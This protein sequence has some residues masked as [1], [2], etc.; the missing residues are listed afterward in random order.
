M[1]TF[2]GVRPSDRV[3]AV[4]MNC[5]GRWLQGKVNKNCKL[6]ITVTLRAQQNKSLYWNWISCPVHDPREAVIYLLIYFAGKT[7][8]YNILGSNSFCPFI[9]HDL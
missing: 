4:N 6:L 3:R 8:I 1:L 9:S 5:G 2:S 7:K